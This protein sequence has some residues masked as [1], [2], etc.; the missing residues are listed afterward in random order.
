M[1]ELNFTSFPYLET[2]RCLLRPLQP[3]DADRLFEMRTNDE[4]LRYLDREKMQTKEE[5]VTMINK[6][7]ASVENNDCVNWVISLKGDDK[8]IGSIAYWRLIKEHYR[9]EIGYNLFPQYWGKG[10]MNEVM[11]IVL[12]FAF[13]QIGLHSIEANV[14]PFNTASIRL[15]ERNGFVREAYFKENYY[16][17]GRFLDTAI[18]SLIAPK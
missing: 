1:L 15:L 7:I 2:E 14:N 11:K 8:M 17:K 16:F 6:I 5:A 18:Y 12:P 9:A 4:V 3:N 13:D 10:I